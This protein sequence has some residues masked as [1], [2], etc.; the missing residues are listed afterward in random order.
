[1]LPTQVAVSLCNNLRKTERGRQGFL[2]RPA[3]RRV[4]DDLAGQP[5]GMDFELAGRARHRKEDGAR[6]DLPQSI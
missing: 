5:G 6:L 2:T 4:L 1:M 3:D